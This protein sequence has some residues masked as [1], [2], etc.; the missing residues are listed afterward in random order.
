MKRY[1]QKSLK[2]VL[3]ALLAY[4]SPCVTQAQSEIPS[5]THPLV[6]QAERLSQDLE[7]SIRAYRVLIERLSELRGEDKLV[8]SHQARLML[9]ENMSK[10]DALGELHSQHVAE[11][12]DAGALET[13]LDSQMGGVRKALRAAAAES[14]S[15]MDEVEVRMTKADTADLFELEQQEAKFQNDLDDLFEAALRYLLVME[16]IGL[17]DQ[18]LR[19]EWEQKLNQHAQLAAGRL[20]FAIDTS[21]RIQVQLKSSPEDS[22]LAQELEASEIAINTAVRSLDRKIEMMHLL[23]MDTTRYQAL[24]VTSTGQLTKG[25]DWKVLIF[26]GILLGFRLIS[27]MVCKAVLAGLDK[28]SI[29]PSQLL[30]SMIATLTGNAVLA[31]GVMIALTQVGISLGPLLAG[32]GVAGF[33][34]GFALQETLANFAAGLMIL[35]YRPFDVGDFV[36]AAGVT[37]TV[38]NMSLVSTTILTLDNQT[39]IVPNGK[40]WGDVIRNVTHQKQRRV[41]LV[42]GIS[43]SDDIPKAEGIL[44]SILEEHPKVLDDPESKVKL[45]E[46]A[47]SS[48]N[49]IVRPWVKTEDY[50]DVYW[51]V[52]RAV[53]MRFD[54]EGIGIPFPQRDVHIYHEKSR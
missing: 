2:P 44:K 50:W 29:K 18:D 13:F 36:G 12:V 24:I 10:F 25:L 19:P 47:E 39:L 32:L 20:R 3:I 43:Y 22:S 42:F 17:G 26:V 4:V 49:F 8:M 15:R 54:E 52:Q 53:K 7:Q 6:T 21:D 9:I 27:R 16:K 37:G 31:M 5:E 41:D 46:L 33:V 38:H 40:I 30:R 48:V 1:L 14:R 23:D 11:N 34:V 51:D 45:H 35:F 28:Y